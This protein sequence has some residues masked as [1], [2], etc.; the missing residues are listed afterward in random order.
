MS[1]NDAHL[2]RLRTICLALPESCETLTWGHPNFRVGKKIF[3]AY[4]RADGISS[5]TFK[6]D[7]LV[8]EHL[9]K[10]D[11]RFSVAH[12]VGHHGWVVMSLSG[13]VNWSEVEEYVRAGYRMIAPKKLAKPV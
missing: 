7:L 12:Y 6:T 8:Q 9:V 2:T 5:V 1:D 13:R 4:S 3:A 11:K 10:T